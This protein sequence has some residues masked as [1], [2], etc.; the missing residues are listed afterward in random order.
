MKDTA[1]PLRSGH[2]ITFSKRRYGTVVLVNGTLWCSVEMFVRHL[3]NFAIETDH[4]EGL[5]WLTS[6]VPDDGT[7]TCGRPLPRSRCEDC[8]V[9]V[10]CI[11]CL[12]RHRRRRLCG[13]LREHANRSRAMGRHEV[14]TRASAIRAYLRELERMG[15]Q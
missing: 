14:V 2:T 11:R 1:I 3:F 8:G 7:C 5:R 10:A 13:L 4:V 6:L 15:H 9:L 12:Y